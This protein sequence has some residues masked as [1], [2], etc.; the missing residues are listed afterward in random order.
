MSKYLRLSELCFRTDGVIG[1]PYLKKL[2]GD[3]KPAGK[4]E[5]AQAS[6]D[7]LQQYLVELIR[8]VVSLHSLL[9]IL[10]CTERL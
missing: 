8:A 9:R 1:I 6:R 10:M 3:K 4:M 2:G 5:Y 7:A